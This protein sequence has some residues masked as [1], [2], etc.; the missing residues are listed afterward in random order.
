MS[1]S[2]KFVISIFTLSIATVFVSEFNSS[3]HGNGNGAPAGKT[4]SPGD[5][6]NCTQCHSGTATIQAG[7]I[8]STIPAAGYTPGQTYTITATI[9]SNPTLEFGFEISPQ[10]TIGTKI[11]TLIVTN[12]TETQL[13]GAGKYITHKSAGTSGAGSKTWTFNWTAPAAGTGAFT[14]YGAFNKTNNNNSSSGD[15]I[16]LSTL[17][18]QENTATGIENTNKDFSVRVFPNPSSDH[19]IISYTLVKNAKVEAKMISLT[20]QLVKMLINEE[21][22]A[23]KI[24][25]RFEIDPS[26]AKG[27]YF[28]TLSVDGI[29]YNQKIIIK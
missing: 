7:L 20:G 9:V 25:N 16:V 14:F 18:V 21:Q 19:F 6:N 27:A 1:I 8:T 23:G 3:V 10:N 28:I 24:E 22:V 26:I 13:V 2:T 11:G 5:G 17:A 12:S 29:N 4:G 15:V